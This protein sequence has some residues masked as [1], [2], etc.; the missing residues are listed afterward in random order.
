MKKRISFILLILIVAIGAFFRLW[1]L[2]SVPPSPS[3]DEV[4]LG[5]NA[6]SILH[7]GRDEYG[8]FLPLL[9]RAYDDYRPALYVYLVIPLIK[10]FGLNI[11]AIRLPSVILSLITIV[12]SYFLVFELFSENAYKKIIAL[13]TSFLLAISPWSIYI[14]RLGH[15]ANLGLTCAVAAIYVFLFSINHPKKRWFLILAAFL[16]AISLDTY[17]SDK[18]FMP[19]MAILLGVLFF[20]QLWKSKKILFISIGF[21]TLVSLPFVFMSLNSQGLTRFD[22]TSAFSNIKPLYEQTSRK[23]LLDRQNHNVIGEIFDNR[24]MV[25]PTIFAKNFISHLDPFW[26]FSNGGKDSFKAP[27]VGLFYSWE[28]FFM[29]A[30]LFLY[31]KLP[32]KSKILIVGWIMAALIAP[33]I[34]TQVPHAM[35]AM[36]ILP[37]PQII[38]ALGI[39]GIIQFLTI[40]KW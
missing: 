13:L 20:K 2:M 8:N 40:K 11:F 23:L 7:T 26:L 4:S 15:E 38:I 3:L 9:L 19:I 39:I 10:L 36:N 12:V 30:G 6:Y 21:G 34:T 27:E 1:M 28:F 35:R 25:I 37:I 31:F 17:Q 5:Y 18:V 22:S 16:F 29:L 24:R 14:S 33:S 32:L